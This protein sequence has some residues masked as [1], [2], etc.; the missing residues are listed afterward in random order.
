M[1]VFAL[2]TEH[3]EPVGF[4]LIAGDEVLDPGPSVRNCMF[5]GAPDDEELLAHPLGRFVSD[6]QF[7]EYLCSIDNT[8][9]RLAV[10]VVIGED[11]VN[12]TFSGEP[13]GAWHVRTGTA[14]S[15]EGVCAIVDEDR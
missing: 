2:M 12:M 5:S 15:V 4:L 10:M 13:L 14:T 9:E 8:F 3:E 1:T 7:E 6:R 11:V